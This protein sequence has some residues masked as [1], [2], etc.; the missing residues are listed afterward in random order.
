MSSSS[1]PVDRIATR[2]RL[3]LHLRAFHRR[4]HAGYARRDPAPAVSTTSPLRMPSPRKR[5]SL[6][7]FTDRLI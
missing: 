6:P 7:G 3:I 2:G 5:M 4:Q 1:L